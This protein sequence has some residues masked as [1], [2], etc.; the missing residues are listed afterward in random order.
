[1]TNDLISAVFV[2]GTLKKG[3]CREQ[4]WPVA[5]LE[6]V[7]AWTFGELY[8]TG[9]Y[10]ALFPGHDLVAGEI[11]R[12]PCNEIDGVLRELDEI[13]EY[14]PG[15]EATNLYNRRVIECTDHSGAVHRAHGY[16]Y[17]RSAEKNFFKRVT[18][19]YLYGDH[20]F[21][22]WPAGSPW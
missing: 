18:A 11:W 21:A 17:A 20:V 16:L 22:I 13:E 4:C 6:T 3:Q 12:F 8:D 19:N 2:Y 10:P 1:M 15:R 14:R 7:K 5:P 9:P